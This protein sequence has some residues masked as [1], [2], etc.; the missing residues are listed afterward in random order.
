MRRLYYLIKNISSAES[1]SDDL[2]MVGITNNKFYILSKRNEKRLC[3]RH[4]H[5]TNPLHK[6][7]IIHGA[8]KGGLLG[9]PI[10]ILLALTMAFMPVF[11]V[12]ANGVSMLFVVG[13]CVL[14]GCWMGGFI[15]VQTENYKIRRFH[16]YLEKGYHLIMVDVQ[17]EQEKMVRK[18]MKENYPDALFFAEDRSMLMP[19]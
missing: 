17:G 1:V 13:F 3:C 5:L 6:S 18:Q 16:G 7:V 11:G 2:H 19:F 15:G 9:L 4:L 12:A 8:E 14:C 10:G